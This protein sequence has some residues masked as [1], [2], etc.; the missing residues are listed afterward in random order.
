[1]WT[2]TDYIKSFGL[3]IDAQGKEYSFDFL[4]LQAIR[5]K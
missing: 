2:P 4:K 5:I 1:M 3:L